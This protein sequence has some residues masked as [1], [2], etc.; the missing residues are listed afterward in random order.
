MT[1]PKPIVI[2]LPEPGTTVSPSGPPAPT[3]VRGE[4]RDP[5]EWRPRGDTTHE[6]V[7]ENQ[8]AVE[9]RSQP[10]HYGTLAQ[11]QPGVL[12][13]IEANARGGLVRAMDQQGI[14]VDERAVRVHWQLV[15]EGY[16]F[17]YPEGF[18]HPEAPDDVQA[19]GRAAWRRVVGFAADSMSKYLFVKVWRRRALP[20]PSRPAMEIEAMGEPVDDVDLPLGPRADVVDAEIVE[21]SHPHGEWCSGGCGGACQS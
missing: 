18:V 10:L 3:P 1:L 11:F 9:V 17:P 7:D 5:T 21:E 8:H 19:E 14:T 4:R 15:V 12:D 2:R 16:G 20:S 13:A 6:R